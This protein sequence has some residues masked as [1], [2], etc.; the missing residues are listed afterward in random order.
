L[1]S[2]VLIK[3]MNKPSVKVLLQAL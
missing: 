1:N 2:K 3:I